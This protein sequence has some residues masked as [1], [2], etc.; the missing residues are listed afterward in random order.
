[1]KV[2]L[3]GLA[4]AVLA[5]TISAPASFA[6]NAPPTARELA[7]KFVSSGD[8]STET[9]LQTA[10]ESITEALEEKGARLPQDVKDW[11][12][13]AFAGAAEQVM[14]DMTPQLE[15]RLVDLYATNFT[16]EELQQVL[17]FQVFVRQPQIAAVIDKA[18]KEK[19]SEARLQVM[20]SELSPEDFNKIMTFTLKPPMLNVTLLT[21]KETKSVL[22]EFT[23]RFQTALLPYCSTAPKGV[24][25]CD[26]QGRQP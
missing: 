23:T 14:N 25:L 16:A 26:K 20:Q 1:M 11:M 9:M 13:I 8:A 12:A 15:Q 7:V 19:T 22:A 5:L 4:S 18:T 6:Q 17:D 3:S 21:L 10:R 2:T 24:A